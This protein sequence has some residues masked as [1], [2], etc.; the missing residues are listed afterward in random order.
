MKI[1]VKEQSQY[2]IT[3][4]YPVCREARMLAK[5]AKTKTLTAGTLSLIAEGG[6]TVSELVKGGAEI[7]YTGPQSMPQTQHST[8]P[9]EG[10]R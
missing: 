10:T 8:T 7:P 6:H 4:F 3:V 5:I 1:L 2:G 9:T